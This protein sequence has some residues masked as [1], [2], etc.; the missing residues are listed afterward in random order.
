MASLQPSHREVE[1]LGKRYARITTFPAPNDTG[2]QIESACQPALRQAQC[3]SPSN[4]LIR[5]QLK[6]W[7]RK[8]VLD[9]RQQSAGG[10]RLAGRTSCNRCWV[11]VESWRPADAVTI[12]HG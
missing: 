12:G 7:H 4:Q 11:N 9:L 6:R 10:S 2:R 3:L 5:G 8:V 1:P